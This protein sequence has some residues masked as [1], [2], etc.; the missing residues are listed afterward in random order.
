M[1]EHRR[2]GLSDE[3]LDAIADKLCVKLTASKGCSIF[4]SEE[5]DEIKNIIKT[6]KRAVWVG[7]AIFFWLL[8]DVYFWVASHISWG[9]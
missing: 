9:K 7:G 5:H 8:K 1:T 4:T 6:K 2:A 3:E